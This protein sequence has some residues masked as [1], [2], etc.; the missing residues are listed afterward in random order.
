M[1]AVQG[2]EVKLAL[3]YSAHIAM[4]SVNGWGAGSGG[5]M[6]HYPEM[7]TWPCGLLRAHLTPQNAALHAGVPHSPSQG[8]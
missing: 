6:G 1:G 5:E 4:L 7:P 2:Q 3:P 8:V